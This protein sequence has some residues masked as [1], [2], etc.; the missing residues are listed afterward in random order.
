MKLKLKNLVIPELY[1]IKDLHR[2][3]Y[4]ILKQIPVL[5]FWKTKPLKILTLLII[6][7]LKLGKLY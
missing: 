1:P 4:I 5:L 2:L 7:K 3:I 6:L